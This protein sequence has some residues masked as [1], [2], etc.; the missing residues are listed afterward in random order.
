[1]LK[2]F[3]SAYVVTG[4]LVESVVCVVS[5]PRYIRHQRGAVEGSWDERMEE[6]TGV[7]GE[8]LWTKQTWRQTLERESSG[9][10]GNFTLG[11]WTERCREEKTDKDGCVQAISLFTDDMAGIRLGIQSMVRIHIDVL[12][13]HNAM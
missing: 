1:M 9:V 7:P 8:M 13:V 3:R 10:W 5:P 2:S 4:A 11:F 6:T 12:Q